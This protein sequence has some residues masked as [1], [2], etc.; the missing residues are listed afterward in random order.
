MDGGVLVTA[1]QKVPLSKLLKHIDKSP[2][3]IATH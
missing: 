2:D 1:L 3:R